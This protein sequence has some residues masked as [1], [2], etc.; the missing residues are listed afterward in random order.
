MAEKP[1]AN[2]S[3]KGHMPDKDET[4]NAH[5]CDHCGSHHARLTA[6][7]AKLGMTAQPGVAKEETASHASANLKAKEPQRERKRH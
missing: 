1:A 5:H 7:E 6:V 2:I 4:P 3:E